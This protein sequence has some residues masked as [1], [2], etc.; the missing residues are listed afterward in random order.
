ML[1][2]SGSHLANKCPDKKPY[3]GKKVFKAN[4]V[5]VVQ[6]TAMDTSTQTGFEFPTLQ[7]D[8]LLKASGIPRNAESFTFA[9]IDVRTHACVNRVLGIH[10]FVPVVSDVC[11]SEGCAE[12]SGTEEHGVI[13]GGNG[14][15]GVALHSE[16][17]IVVNKQLEDHNSDYRTT[18][19][20]SKGVDGGQDIWSGD[21]RGV[22]SDIKLLFN[23]DV[24]RTNA[25]MCINSK[26]HIVYISVANTEI[27]MVL[28]SGSEL[29][30]LRKDLLPIDFVTT[31]EEVKHIQ[32]IGAFGGPVNAEITTVDVALL[33]DSRVHAPVSLKVALCPE[34]NGDSGLL[35]LKDYQ[36]LQNAA[37]CWT[38]VGSDSSDSLKFCNSLNI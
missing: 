7:V 3:T 23:A 20:H 38:S 18:E 10:G 4:R 29:T 8:A 30:V 19:V 31:Y 33:S 1:C 5:S 14:C 15:G 35:S 2:N 26:G 16:R 36:T 9:P 27:P 22:L 25:N 32:L 21:D 28:D 6:S 37:V 12:E 13:A 11:C 17:G 24:V 34:L